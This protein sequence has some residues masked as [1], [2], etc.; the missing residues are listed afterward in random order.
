MRRVWTGPGEKHLKQGCEG[1]NG[2]KLSP[3]MNADEKLIL[4]TTAGLAT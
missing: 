1:D 2:K 3:P 4:K